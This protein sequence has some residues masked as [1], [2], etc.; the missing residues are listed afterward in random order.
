MAL[1]ALTL[2]PASAEGLR[3]AQPDTLARLMAEV[4]GIL[5]D[6]GVDEEEIAR[7]LNRGLWTVAGAVRLPALAAE[8]RLSFAAGRADAVLPADFQHGPTD[9]FLLPGSDRMRLVPDLAALRRTVPSGTGCRPR[10]ASVGGG[11]LWL[12]PVPRTAVGVAIGYYRLPARLVAPSDRPECLP[13][14]LAGPLLVDFACRDLFE[15]LEEGSGDRKVQATAYGRR[16][17]AGLAGLLALFGPV[18]RQDEPVDIP[19][20]SGPWPAGGGWA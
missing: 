10:Y 19:A 20:A 2:P 7:T 8:A 12:R 9:A 6:P 11:R 4:A 17:E 5:G 13:P 14:H 3:S 18:S 15:R 16:F 1:A